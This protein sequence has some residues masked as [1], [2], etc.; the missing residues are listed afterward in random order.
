MLWI[1][2]VAFITWQRWP[3][4]DWTVVKVEPFDP[5]E[6][7]KNTAK[8]RPESTPMPSWSIESEMPSAKTRFNSS[9]LFGVEKQAYSSKAALE[10][11]RHDA[12]RTGAAVGI[13]PPVAVLMLGMSLI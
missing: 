1:A 10:A 12:L 2:S 13:T 11:E 8:P 5:D 6:Y 9:K 3:I 7:L 4:D